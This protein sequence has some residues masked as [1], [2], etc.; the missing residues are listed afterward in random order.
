MKIE[1]IN[2]LLTTMAILLS[3]CIIELNSENF[4]LEIQEANEEDLAP[5]S[6]KRKIERTYTWSNII[7]KFLNESDLTNRI[8]WL[9]INE[10]FLKYNSARIPDIYLENIKEII[11]REEKILTDET[12]YFKSAKISDQTCIKDFQMVYLNSC[13]IFFKLNNKLDED[14]LSKVIS[15]CLTNAINDMGYYLKM[16]FDFLNNYKEN[17]SKFVKSTCDTFLAFQTENLATSIFEINPDLL[18]YLAKIITLDKSNEILFQEDYKIKII[19]RLLPSM[20]YIVLELENLILEFDKNDDF[21]SGEENLGT[22]S[23]HKILSSSSSLN[24]FR[25]CISQILCFNNVK[26]T[27]YTSNSMSVSS[28]LSSIVGFEETQGNDFG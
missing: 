12:V 18:S 20:S 2:K 8:A 1:S 17:V 23:K 3:N 9:I 28:I 16:V 22:Y 7:N 24:T 10:Q 21:I 26:R 27:V 25:R 14:F 11:L 13:L 19:N 6:K 4:I 5:T 15:F